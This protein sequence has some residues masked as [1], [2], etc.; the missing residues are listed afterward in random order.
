[1]NKEIKQITISGMKDITVDHTD[2]K[3]MKIL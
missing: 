3:R 1:M 2:I